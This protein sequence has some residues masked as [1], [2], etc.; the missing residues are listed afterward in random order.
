MCKTCGC[1]NGAAMQLELY[2][3]DHDGRCRPQTLH[4]RLM[5]APGVLHV[6]VDEDAGRVLADFNPQQT[7]AQELER[8]AVEAGYAVRR[9]EIREMDHQH[10]I[11]A[12][13]KRIAGKL[14]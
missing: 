5:G 10:G 14:T 3:E 12:F 2:V 4:A 6:K 11:T 13:L 9:A 8:L 1:G 7:S